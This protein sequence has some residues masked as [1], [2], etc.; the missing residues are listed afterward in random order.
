MFNADNKVRM[1]VVKPET[2]KEEENLQIQQMSYDH[3]VWWD[4][5]P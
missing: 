5:I 1:N 2:M 4:Q 3:R